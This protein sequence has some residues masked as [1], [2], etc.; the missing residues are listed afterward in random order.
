MENTV[1]RLEVRGEATTTAFW[2]FSRC[3]ECGGANMILKDEKSCRY[4]RWK[5][6]MSE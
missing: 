1:K 4:P 5:P 2:V 3:F 6:G